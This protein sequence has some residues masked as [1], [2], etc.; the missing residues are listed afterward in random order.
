MRLHPDDITAIAS[1]VADQMQQFPDPSQRWAGIKAASKF[2]DLSPDR[3]R[4]LAEAKK[5]I[6]YKDPDHK[7]NR[8]TFDLASIHHYKMNP[9]QS[10]TDM[11][12]KVLDFLQKNRKT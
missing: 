5:I 9:I 8:W 4:A 1:A 2:A 10:K 6:G 12:N 3:L 7:L 11:E